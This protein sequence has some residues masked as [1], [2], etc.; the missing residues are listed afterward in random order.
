MN[1]KQKQ[2]GGEIIA[3]GGFGCI[4]S[5]A[6]QCEGSKDGNSATTQTNT[7]SKLMTTKHAEEEYQHI[8]QFKNALQ[9]IPQYQD[10]FLLKGFSLCKPKALSAE[11]L[12]NYSTDCKALTKK[13]ITAENVNQS[14]NKLLAITMPNGGT[15]AETFIQK[16]FVGSTILQLNNSL[17][18]LL[19]N[20]IIPMNR[21][22]AYHG[23]IKDANV[24]VQPNTN[25]DQQFMYKTRL[26]DWGLSFIV[27][28][29]YVKGIP[30]KL[31]RRPFQYNVPFS[32]V[33]FNKD[34]VRKYNLF[35]YLNKNPDYFQIREFVTNYI[36]LW[37]E[38]RGPGHLDAIND[39]IKKLTIRELPAVKRNKIKNHL[40]EY[41]FTYYY[42][43][44][45]LSKVL[46]KYTNN[47]KF[48]LIT[49][50]NNVFLK[51]LDVW[52][53]TMI[54]ITMFEHLYANYSK[55]NEVEMQ[56]ILKIKYI[57]VHFLYENPTEPIDVV[58]LVEELKG[59][60][61]LLEQIGSIPITN[62]AHKQNKR[63]KS[64][65]RKMVIVKGKKKR[66][67]RKNKNQ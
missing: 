35:L 23:D 17:I 30:K 4:F 63:N 13:G 11:D 2:I 39:I 26:I 19:V 28:T 33:L 1:I 64:K 67:T 3:S 5:P 10:Y 8:Q 7:I 14:L 6:L 42:I 62:K 47:G 54:Y 65:S 20:G 48:D 43:I 66:K 55:L 32:S 40:I 18:N 31:Y 45:Y 61:N 58:S 57:I 16:Y 56:F 25:I 52:G 60:N 53:F 50:I 24:L 59:L 21:L 46:E 34:F 12:S 15:D 51:N 27:K 41:E 29:G 38:I 9:V 37:N 22:H 49:Y 36:F 44:E